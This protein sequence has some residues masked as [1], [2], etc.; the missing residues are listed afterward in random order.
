[1]FKFWWP[2]WSVQKK[3]SRVR[4]Y[5][6]ACGRKIPLSIL[7]TVL[8]PRLSNCVTCWATPPAIQNSLRQLPSAATASLEA[9]K[10]CL[11]SPWSCLKKHLLHH[12]R[13]LKAANQ[14][15]KLSVNNLLPLTLTLTQACPAPAVTPHACSLP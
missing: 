7:T 1:H 5:G 9:R 12:R 13:N 8:I 3:S 14:P 2:C 4:S 6:S 10:S 11:I 15:R